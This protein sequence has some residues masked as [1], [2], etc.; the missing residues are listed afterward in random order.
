MQYVML[1]CAVANAL[2]AIVYHWLEGRF[3]TTF[4]ALAAFCVGLYALC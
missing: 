3:Q 1:A 2:Q 4:W